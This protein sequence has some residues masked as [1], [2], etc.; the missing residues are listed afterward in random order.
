MTSLAGLVQFLREREKWNEKRGKMMV[1]R[2][3][4][5]TN[6]QWQSASH[7]ELQDCKP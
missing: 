3:N 4:A 7:K 5:M 2:F 6:E 1:A